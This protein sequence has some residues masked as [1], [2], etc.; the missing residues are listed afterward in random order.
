M[1]THH[2]V[3]CGVWLDHSRF[4]DYS[5]FLNFQIITQNILNN[6]QGDINHLI[7]PQEAE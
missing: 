4:Y 5:E 1:L 3:C 7:R 2:V 6:Y